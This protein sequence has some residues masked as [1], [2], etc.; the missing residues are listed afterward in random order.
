MLVG[1]RGEQQV[2][3]NGLRRSLVELY[4]GFDG[5]GGELKEV[6]AVARRV[7]VFGT[8]IGYRK[9]RRPEKQ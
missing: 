8:G 9:Q 6:F 4:E 3:R 7:W 2:E 5:V 1:E